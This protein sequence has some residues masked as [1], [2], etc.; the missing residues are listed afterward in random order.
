MFLADWSLFPPNHLEVVKNRIQEYT[1]KLARVERN[2]MRLE[3]DR[4]GYQN[5]KFV[6]MTL[7]R[8]PNQALQTMI[9]AFGRFSE[10]VTV[11]E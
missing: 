9:P 8:K 2:I 3:Q 6:H 7:K 11:V 5:M 1:D 10:H 4:N